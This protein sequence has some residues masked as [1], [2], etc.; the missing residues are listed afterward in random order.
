[1]HDVK[2]ARIAG[3]RTSARIAGTRAYT[4][5]MGLRRQ[6]LP[7][8]AAGHAA[9]SGRGDAV[10]VVAAGSSPPEDG[11][12]R[13]E[14]EVREA[15]GARVRAFRKRLDMSGRD[16]AAAANVT[17]GFISQ[18]ERG[19]VNP[20]VATLLRICSALGVRIG[21]VFTEPN[22]PNRLIRRDER[23]IYVVPDSGFEE[24]RISVD[25]RG[26]VQLV[27]SRIFPG[28]GTGEELLRHGSETEC[29]YV[30]KGSLEV[31][32]G[33]DRHVLGPGDCLTIPGDL[34]HGCFNRGDEI[35]EALWI[36]SPAV[37]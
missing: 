18:M 2:A 36:T 20:S 8:E 28:G 25:S 7:R 31:V 17:P 3:A 11:V 10:S 29:V 4:L 21:D 15:L 27:W 26:I 14:R 13:D 30:L 12:S 23:S 9:D 5:S 33:E 16:L 34:P 35:V 32:A 6:G 1:V 22:E 24:A 37:Y 19:L